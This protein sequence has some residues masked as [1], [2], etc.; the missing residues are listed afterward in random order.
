MLVDLLMFELSVHVLEVLKGSSGVESLWAGEGA[1]TD[2]VALSKLHVATK[3]LKSLVGILITRVNDPPVCLHE[4]SRSQVILRV[5][6]VAGA[7]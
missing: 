1:E 2:L 3:H 7:S 4:H 5:P 6:P